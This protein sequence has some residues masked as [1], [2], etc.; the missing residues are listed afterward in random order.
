MRTRTVERSILHYANKERK[1]RGLP[2][3]SGH[4]ALIEAARRHSRWMAKTGRFGHTGAGG[5]THSER[6]SKAGYVGGTGENI[7]QTPTKGGKGRAWK[8]RFQWSSD[9]ELD[10]AA[11]ITWMYSL[12]HR[13]NMLSPD[14]RHIGIGVAESKGGQAYLTQCFGSGLGLP[15]IV[16]DPLRMP[17]RLKRLPRRL[18]RLLRHL[19]GK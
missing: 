17:R 14:Y 13:K 6:T 3:L 2:V 5:S 1:K 16:A 8:S 18:R 4:P 15:M 10:K 9:R 11:V 12:G 19:A 7:W